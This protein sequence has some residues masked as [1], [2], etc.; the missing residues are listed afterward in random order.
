MPLEALRQ[1]V[2]QFGT[3]GA[4]AIYEDAAAELQPQ[5]VEVDLQ[6]MLELGDDLPTFVGQIPTVLTLDEALVW[7]ARVRHNN[8]SAGPKPILAGPL[9]STVEK[10]AVT[11]TAVVIA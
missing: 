8:P 11:D 1:A 7:L 9:F 4:E 2:V 6:P 3:D 5:P 10:I